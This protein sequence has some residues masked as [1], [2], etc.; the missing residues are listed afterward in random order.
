MKQKKWIAIGAVLAVCILVILAVLLNRNDN[1]S[2]PETTGVVP[3][4][5]TVDRTESEAGKDET[6]DTKSADTENNA[7]E[8]ATTEI[9]ATEP[10]TTEAAASLIEDGGDVEIIIPDDQGS[11]GF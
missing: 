9:I 10:V 6:N 1:E 3:V 7:T 11:G 2:A 4:I 8:P 5:P